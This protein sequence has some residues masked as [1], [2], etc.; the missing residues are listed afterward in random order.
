MTNLQQLVWPDFI[1]GFK[2]RWVSPGT[3]ANNLVVGS[4]SAFIPGIPGVVVSTGD[5]SP[6]SNATLALNTM[7][8][9]YLYVSGGSPAIEMVT[10]E[11]SAVYRGGARTKSTDDTRRYI[12][13]VKTNGV[14]APNTRMWSFKHDPAAGEI[15]YT[16]QTNNGVA[17]WGI[18]NAGI[19]AAGTVY[20]FG[21]TATA[22]KNLVPVSGSHLKVAV[23]GATVSVIGAF[24]TSEDANTDATGADGI[25]FQG[26]AYSWVDVPLNAS[27]QM[28]FYSNSTAYV[29][30]FG[31]RYSR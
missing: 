28:I 12:G 8:H 21:S 23:L 1:S 6:P 31:Y 4:G 16:E 20:H 9:V 19:S 5:L 14:A 15:I 26:T 24:Q 29:Y 25:Y 11:P 22:E 27:Q 10:T 7:Y 17:P 13:S 3:N 2:M 30:M 18:L